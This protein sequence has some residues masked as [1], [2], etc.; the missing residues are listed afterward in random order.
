MDS[1]DSGGQHENPVGVLTVL[2][3][4]ALIVVGDEVKTPQSAALTNYRVNLF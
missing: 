4:L 2:R 3:Q 1:S